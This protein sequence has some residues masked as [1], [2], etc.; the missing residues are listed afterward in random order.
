MRSLTQPGFN[1]LIVISA[2]NLK[3]SLRCLYDGGDCCL[4]SYK[5]DSKYCQICTCLG[6]K[7]YNFIILQHL[8][9]LPLVSGGDYQAIVDDNNLAAFEWETK[10]LM[11]LYKIILLIHDV[12]SGKVCSLLCTNKDIQ[13]SVNS[14]IY[15]P[16]DNSCICSWMEGQLCIETIGKEIDSELLLDPEQF[17]KVPWMY[18]DLDRVDFNPSCLGNKTF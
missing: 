13:S 6:G 4:D 7:F 12:S 3:L 14:W 9:L 2:L 5:K 16:L 17:Q 10:S 1:T 18:A 8:I 15:N 11:H